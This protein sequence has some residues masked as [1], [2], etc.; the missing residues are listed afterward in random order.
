MLNV[1]T[2]ITSGTNLNLD[3]EI[4][5]P[6]IHLRSPTPIQASM[7]T[8]RVYENHNRTMA[9]MHLIVHPNLNSGQSPDADRLLANDSRR[10]AILTA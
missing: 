7:L 2:L 9:G 5:S 10:Q 1:P 4:I 6:A 8:R 3:A